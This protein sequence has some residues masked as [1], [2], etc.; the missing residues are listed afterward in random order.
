MQK[1]I[2]IFTFAIYF[3]SSYAAKVNLNVIKKWE[4]KYPTSEKTR[5]KDIFHVE[6]FKKA[7]LE[8]ITVKDYKELRPL[9]VGAAVESSLVKSESGELL[10]FTMC[11]THMCGDYIFYFY[12]NLKS[13][14]LSVCKKMD[15]KVIWFGPMK[16][17]QKAECFQ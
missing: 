7:L 15:D 4:N 9:I 16:K 2:L 14:E 10:S 13:G 8:I 11:K 17:L 5:N 3:N 12:I 1:L 6:S